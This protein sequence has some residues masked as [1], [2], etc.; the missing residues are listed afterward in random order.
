MFIREPSSARYIALASL[1]GV[2]SGSTVTKTKLKIENVVLYLVLENSE[3]Q[4]LGES[5]IQQTSSPLHHPSFLSSLPVFT[6]SLCLLMQMLCLALQYGLNGS[7]LVNYPFHVLQFT[8][9]LLVAKEVQFFHNIGV[10]SGIFAIYL[11]YPS[12]EPRTRKENVI[13]YILCLLFVLCAVTVVC[14]LL[15]YAF[16][17]SNNPIYRNTIFIISFAVSYRCTT[18][19]TSN[20]L[21]PNIK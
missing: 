20:C 17:V 14:D 8:P 13:F 10:Y 5:S 6:P 4:V 15:V 7:S 3:V 9:L 1:A 11:Q 16:T 12:K 19:S 2:V 18:A 21:N